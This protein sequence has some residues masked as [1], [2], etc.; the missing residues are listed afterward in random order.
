MERHHLYMYMDSIKDKYSEYQ[1]HVSLVQSV[2]IYS[3]LTCAFSLDI[4]QYFTAC[5]AIDEAV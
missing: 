1:W 3:K 5:K 4:T 2:E